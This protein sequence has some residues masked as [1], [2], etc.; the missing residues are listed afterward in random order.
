MSHVTHAMQHTQHATTNKKAKT[1]KHRWHRWTTNRHHV[2]R[3]TRAGAGRPVHEVI[4]AWRLSVL[5]N[6]RV[7]ERSPRY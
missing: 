5:F 4:V 7:H 6:L 1:Q 3:H 2:E